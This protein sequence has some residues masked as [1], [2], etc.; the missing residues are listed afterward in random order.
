MLLADGVLRLYK[1]TNS[2]EAGDMPKE[3]L[4]RTSD[5]DFFYSNRTVGFSRQYAAMGVDQR[6]DRLVRIWDTPV[7]IGQYAVLDGGDQ[8]RIDNVQMIVDD[9]GLKVVD[10]TLRRLEENYDVLTEQA[11]SLQG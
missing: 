8:Y 1:L 3:K 11:E 5:M 4:V 2:A 9:E 6:I 7:E 10:L